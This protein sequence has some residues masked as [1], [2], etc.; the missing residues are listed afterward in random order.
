MSANDIVWMVLILA[1]TGWLLYRS[2]WKKRGQCHGCS[3]GCC[4]KK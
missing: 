4:D 2:L 1:G 3:G